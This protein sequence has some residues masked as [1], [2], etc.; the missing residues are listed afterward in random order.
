M[1]EHDYR[2]CLLLNRLIKCIVSIRQDK[3]Q[4]GQAVVEFNDHCVSANGV[5][6]LQ[7]NILVIV[8]VPMRQLLR[9]FGIA[10]YYIKFVPRFAEITN[11]LR[12]MLKEDAVWNWTEICT[13]SFN[14]I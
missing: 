14:E 10:T 8:N 5:Q 11:P 3:C 6:L 13:R 9:F 7:S 1:E 4:I 2:L 12:Q